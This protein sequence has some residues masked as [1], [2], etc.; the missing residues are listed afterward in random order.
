MRIYLYIIAGI[1][2][3][4][5][6]WNISQFLLV[7]LGIFKNQQLEELILFPCIAIALAVGMVAN[8]IF[9]SSPTRITLC[10]RKLKIPILIA[11]GLGA[12]IGLIAGAISQLLYLPQIPLGPKTVRALS[13]LFIGIAVGLSEGLS[14]WWN[15]QESGNKKRFTQRLFIS[16]FGAVLASLIAASI[17]E[18]IRSFENVPVWF[19][20]I[21]APLGF[22]ILGTLLGLTFSLTNSPSYMAALRAGGGFEFTDSEGIYDQVGDYKPYPCIAESALKF[23]TESDPEDFIEEGLSI[24]LPAKGKILI[25]SEN[26][27]EAQIR[28]PGVSE[29]AAHID[30]TSRQAKLKPN[31]QH[32]KAI[33]INGVPLTSRNSVNLKHND[34][35]TFYTQTEGYIH[36]EKIYRF[37]YY[38]RFLDPQA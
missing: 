37:V 22:S 13:W 29:E 2:S 14:W 18:F 12:V 8:E 1:T 21:E 28:L 30:L 24:Q 17:F 3:A 16:L 35:V 20:K 23:V 25:G 15:A 9:V 4:L 10:L 27:K 33:A 31:P 32:Y 7:D 6:G 34:I 36:E 5:I 11:L 38:N 19:K 26:N